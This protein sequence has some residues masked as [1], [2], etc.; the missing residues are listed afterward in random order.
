MPRR[1]LLAVPV[2]LAVLVG[3]TGAVQPTVLASTSDDPDLLPIDPAKGFDN[4]NHLIFIVQENR[5]FDH[6]FGTFPGAN[7]I[8]RN[9][10]PCLPDPRPD[11]PCQPS[12]HDAGPYDAGAAHNQASSDTA[13]DGGK[14]DGF[15]R[16]IF[17]L[18]TVCQRQ[19]TKFECAQAAKDTPSGEPVDVM[20]YHDAREIPNYWAYAKR[21]Q[22]QDRM[23]APM[24]SWTLPAHLYMVSAW[25]AAC[26]DRTDV[27]SCRTDLEQPNLGWRTSDGG[28]PPYLW[29]DITW[30]MKRHDVDWAYYVGEGTCIQAPCTEGK[31][32]VVL[33]KN[34]LVGFKTVIDSGQLDNIKLYRDYYQAAKDG[35][36]PAVSW[37]APWRDPSEHPPLSIEPGQ[38]YVTNLIN[39][40]MQGPDWQHTAIFLFWDDW[41]GFY[42]H[43]VPPK[44]DVAGWGIRVPSMVIS[45]WVDRKLNVDHGTYSFDAFLKLIEDRFLDG[46]RLNPATDGWWD[47]RP[48]IREEIPIL[49]DLRYAFNFD[50]QPIPKLILDPWPTKN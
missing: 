46:E 32:A 48:T 31:K 14:M 11:H 16:A 38:A 24:D 43:V 50:Q 8:P 37:I 49:D 26:P 10:E 39:A 4:I 44:V 33:G 1:F 27:S 7:G 45:P 3:L 23:F 22:L 42:D 18:Y 35:T 20:G 47:P 36:L 29:A 21:Y 25:A 15:V 9:P 41:G 40:A 19:P 2:L 30:L 13:I 12:F 6:Y 34:P 17:N 28:K 5:S